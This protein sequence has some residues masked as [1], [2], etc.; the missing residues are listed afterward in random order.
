MKRKWQANK[1]VWVHSIHTMACNHKCISTGN[2]IHDQLP[3]NARSQIPLSMS[4][5]LIVALSRFERTCRYLKIKEK[6]PGIMSLHHDCH[7]ADHKLID[8]QQ[9][10]RRSIYCH[11]SFQRKSP[12]QQSLPSPSG[13]R[14][15]RVSTTG[16]LPLPLIKPNLDSRYQGLLGS[17]NFL[18]WVPG[19]RLVGKRPV[20]V[21]VMKGAFDQHK[22]LADGGLPGR[23]TYRVRTTLSP[24]VLL[25][26][27]PGQAGVREVEAAVAVD[28]LDIGRC[29]DVE[30]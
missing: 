7:I 23:E 4:G 8:P 9:R 1:R 11:R 2:F 29:R 21:P 19:S 27:D 6:Y 17:K 5:E 28:F 18:G 13:M 3:V 20:L 14:G 25:A 15:M 24:R 16:S 12:S 22:R 10:S 30:C 26:V